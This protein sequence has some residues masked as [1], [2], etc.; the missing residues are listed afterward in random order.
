[1]ANIIKMKDPDKNH[2]KKYKKSITYTSYFNGWSNDACAAYLEN[3]TLTK[4]K[5]EIMGSQ[6]KYP[7]FS[8]ATKYI[9]QV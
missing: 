7:Q 8:G 6:K 2:L 5:Q 9:P 1:M 3:W 4:P